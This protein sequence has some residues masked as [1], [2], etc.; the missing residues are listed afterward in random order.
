MSASFEIK[1]WCPGALR[2]MESGDGLVVRVRPHGGCLSPAQARSIAQGARLHGN[3]LIDL[4]SRANLQ[5]RGVRPHSHLP[6]LQALAAHGLIDGDPA[7]EARRNIIVTPLGAGEARTQTLELARRLEA[8]LAQGPDLPGKFGFAVDTAATRVLAT[9]PA[10]IRIERDAAGYLLVR[11]EGA[12]TGVC[13]D[14]STAVEFAL[15]MARWFVASGGVVVGRGRMARHLAAGARLDPA[16]SGD[17]RPAQVTLPMVGPCGEGVLVGA[18]FGQLEAQVLD[19]LAQ[20][21]R[22]IRVTPWRMLLVVG[23][24]DVPA[25]EGL[26]LTP[27]DPLL[28]VSACS[29]A[30]ACPQALAPTRHLARHLAPFVPPGRHLHV[31]GCA[32]GCARQEAAPFTL[33]ATSSG[34]DLILEGN[35]RSVPARSGLSE[36]AIRANPHSLF[37][38]A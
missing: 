34:F 35:A 15:R 28:A 22:E 38:P 21:G 8:G 37:E 25:I 19:T 31:S 7:L 18:A 3:G 9:A 4:T 14:A 6:L 17:A 23:A 12:A 27:G 29:G 20:L 13:A 11:A 36:A 26:T 2:P 10:D 5:I 1:G 33:C 24:K 16:L 30:P 32:K